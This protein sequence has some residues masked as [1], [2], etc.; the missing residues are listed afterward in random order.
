MATWSAKKG[1][2]I[3]SMV[4]TVMPVAFFLKRKKPSVL[5]GLA[6]VYPRAP[7]PEYLHPVAP[8]GNY[9]TMKASSS[10]CE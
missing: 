8:S 1:D 7:E 6:D 3:G 4:L 9:T 10:P 2:P 5:M